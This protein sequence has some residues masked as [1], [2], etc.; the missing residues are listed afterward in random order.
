MSGRPC[1][2]EFRATVEGEREKLRAAREA[3]T[4]ASGSPSG[5]RSRSASGSVSGSANGGDTHKNG[6]DTHR[7]NQ[8]YLRSSVPALF[9]SPV[10]RQCSLLANSV[11]PHPLTQE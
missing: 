11:P 7:Y 8:D 3:S 1:E 10:P 9:P 5:S 4:S 6:G 2:K